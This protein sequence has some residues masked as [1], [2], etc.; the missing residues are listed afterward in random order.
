MEL[1]FAMYDNVKY[2]GQPLT[3]W[4]DEVFHNMYSLGELYKMV[5]DGVNLMSI[6]R[7]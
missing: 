4:R 6:V 2:L 1:L 3:W 5:K 7:K